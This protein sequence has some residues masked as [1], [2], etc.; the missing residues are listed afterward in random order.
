MPRAFTLLE[1]VLVMALLA[2]IA[3]FSWPYMQRQFEASQL[4]ESADQFRSLLTLTRAQAMIDARR[5]RIR[6]EPEKRHPIIECETDP[7]QAPGKYDPVKADWAVDERLLGETQVHEIRAGRPD[8]TLPFDDQQSE[9]EQDEGFT[10]DSES[11]E[12]TESTSDTAGAALP[13]NDSDKA[14]QVPIDEQRPSI[15][16]ETDGSTDWATI[17]LSNIAPADQLEEDERQIW[18][19]IDGRTGLARIRESLTADQMADTTLRTKRSKLLPPEVAWGGDLTIN[20]STTQPAGGGTTTFGGLPIGV[21][22][23]GRGRAGGQPTGGLPSLGGMGGGLPTGGLPTGGLPQFGQGGG[24][25]NGAGGDRPNRGGNRPPRNNNPR[26]ESG[27]AKDPDNKPPPPPPPPDDAPKPPADETP[28]PPPDNDEP[29]PNE[30]D[31][32]TPNPNPDDPNKPQDEDEKE[33]T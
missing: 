32:A 24:Q 12:T 19:E 3:A 31:G 33:P 14:D 23:G 28:K 2:A 25:G 30:A 18:I 10:L 4:T 6:F 26:P 29:K 9:L 13:E 7:F 27:G 15:V 17:I 11:G 1:V 5:Y 8:Y 22:Q 20:S 21:N 16:F